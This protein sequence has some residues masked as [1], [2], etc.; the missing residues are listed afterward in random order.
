MDAASGMGGDMQ[1]MQM[2][3]QQ[4]QEQEDRRTMILEQILEPAA[5]DRMKRLAM[6]KIE[7]A[8]A[9]E[10]SL[11]NA[12]TN[13]KLK[14]KVSEEQLIVMLEQISGGSET[15]SEGGTGKRGIVVQRR[16][17]G[18]DDDDDDNDDDLR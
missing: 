8:R 5:K 1:E 12:A 9:V 15:A 10:D 14:S 18:F 2:R 16:K 3:Q 11:I 6:V 4:Q 7:K 13:G 17:T